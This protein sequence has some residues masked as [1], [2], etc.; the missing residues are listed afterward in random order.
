SWPDGRE[1]GRGDLIHD[2]KGV[3]KLKLPPLAPG[4]YRVRYQTTDDFGAKYDTWKELV[5]ASKTTPLA[6]PLALIA[7]RSPVK[8][9]GTARF[10]AVSGLP[11]QLVYFDIYRSGKLAERRRL[12]TGHSPSLVEIPVRDDDRGGF[13]VALWAVRDHQY[14]GFEQSIFV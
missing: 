11:D 10:L 12:E 3:A 9:G 1:E 7:E 6:L 4:A 2:D 14:M 8:V 13:G 5:V